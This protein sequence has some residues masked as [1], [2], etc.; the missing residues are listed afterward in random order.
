MTHLSSLFTLN[1]SP[2]QPQYIPSEPRCWTSWPVQSG[3]LL[4]VYQFLVSNSIVKM[5]DVPRPA[6]PGY[7]S[8][9]RN[10]DE[11]C[12][13]QEE[14]FATRNVPNTELRGMPDNDDQRHWLAGILFDAILDVSNTL[15]PPTSQQY[16]YIVNP[17]RFPSEVVDIVSWRLLVS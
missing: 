7:V 17:D 12:R 13:R 2:P 14:H 1:Y 8:T 5:S 9:I 15:E 11:A 4:T 3:W 10:L 6:R 16:R